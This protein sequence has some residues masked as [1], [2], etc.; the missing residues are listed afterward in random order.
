M[1]GVQNEGKIQLCFGVCLCYTES[2]LSVDVFWAV[3]LGNWGNI[4]K[5]RTFLPLSLEIAY[6]KMDEN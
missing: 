1:F 4:D 2:L 6:L 5:V 3:H